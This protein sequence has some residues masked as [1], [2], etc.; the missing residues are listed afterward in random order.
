MRG[1]G[2]GPG[3]AGRP[4]GVAQLLG[5]RATWAIII[6]NIV[7]HWGYF[8]YLNWIPSYLHAS[9]PTLCPR[10]PVL[11]PAFLDVELWSRSRYLPH[12]FWSR[13]PASISKRVC[14]LC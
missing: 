5:S 6:V 13:S 3:V 7:N 2:T 1:R 14:S 9:H 10:A 12:Q 8:I 4:V 11:H